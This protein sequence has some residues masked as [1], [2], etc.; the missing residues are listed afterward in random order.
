MDEQTIIGQMKHLADQLA[1][2]RGT[3]VAVVLIEPTIDGYAQVAPQLVMEDACC[4]ST[5]KWPNDFSLTLLN[6]HRLDGNLS[7]SPGL[8]RRIDNP[9]FL[10]DMAMV[11]REIM[12]CF[13]RASGTADFSASVLSELGDLHAHLASM[14]QLPEAILVD[15]AVQLLR[16]GG[17]PV[18]GTN[19]L[20]KVDVALEVCSEAV[21]VRGRDAEIPSDAQPR[22]SDLP[23]SFFKTSP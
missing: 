5:G 6:G 20:P 12:R 2:Q 14:N 9:E 8:Q 22:Y 3:P 4:S 16:V 21:S 17:D 23:E 11:G 7:N 18:E 10:Q 13:G 1:A 19:R 15:A